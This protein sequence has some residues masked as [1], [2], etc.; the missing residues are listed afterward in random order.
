MRS[1][2]H[3]SKRAAAG[4]ARRRPSN[5]RATEHAGAR[6]RSSVLE[7]EA[8]G[9]Y[10][11]WIALALVAY[12]FANFAAAGRFEFVR[13]DDPDYVTQNPQV[14]AGLSWHGVQWAIVTGHAA[15]WHPL[16]WLSHM[17]DVQL[18]GLNAGSHHLMNV[19]F[20]VLNTLLL[21][22]VLYR[23]T[24]AVGRSAFVAALFAVHPLH[25]ESVAWVSE[26]KDVLSTCM[27]MLTLL[28]YLSFVRRASAR[29]YA[30]VLL[31][32]ALGLM[33]K[34]M[35]VTLP[36]V[37]L[38]LDVWPLRRIALWPERG[39]LLAP[40]DRS[41]AMHLM[42]EKL[43]MVFLAVVSSVITVAVQRSGGAV[44]ALSA[45]PLGLRIENAVINCVAYIG[46]MVW[47]A[48]LAA[49]YPYRESVSIWAVVGSAL[50]L[51]LI[52]AASV[53]LARRRPYVLV[54]WLWYIG[55]L[56]P[57]IGIVQVGMQSMA[58]RYSYI[59]LIGLFIIIA[60]GGA[61]VLQVMPQQRVVAPITAGIVL[62]ACSARTHAQLETWRNSLA[63]WQHAVDVTSNNAYAQYNLGVVLVQLGRVDDGIARFREAL[64]VDPNYADVHIDLANALNQRGQADEAIGEF[65]TVV[66]LRPDY[67]D[68]R[69][70]YG[71]LLRTHGRNAEAMTQLRE[72]LRLNPELASAH[73]ELGNALTNDGK[74]ADA[75]TEYSAA[76]RLDP[77]FAE[78][79]NN[80]GAA[81]MRAGQYERAVAEFLEAV[82]LRPND[83]M[84]HYNAALML[85][86]IGRA[87][88]AVEH[89]EAVLRADP[90][91][92]AARRAMGRLTAGPGGA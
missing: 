86:R 6:A 12:T 83:V 23:A 61:E 92:E 28:A 43:P 57:V 29:R 14:L 80:L 60:W 20:H 90:N 25:V 85:E 17:L 59:P 53:R 27:W 58:D 41:T 62:I 21:F 31:C 22:A 11:W 68:A 16:T 75:I 67:A 88:E 38:L 15:N 7:P 34:P 89:L 8:T 9:E 65:A 36:F 66:R 77:K 71:S 49:F 5:P 48:R 3:H 76:V 82:R 35:V 30:A 73:D 37:L 1:K 32:F 79:H 70:A 87:K 10:R 47:P 45:Y 44:G 4:L 26:R 78:G 42:L 50:L 2:G 19:G 69:V 55:T 52:T 46:R 64:R 81:L 18:F 72:A 54:G 24:R 13:F 40:A 63:L 39:G 74:L 91:N 33:A 51:V 84:F 56:M